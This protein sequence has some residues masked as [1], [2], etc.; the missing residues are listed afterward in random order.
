MKAFIGS[1][2]IGLSRAKKLKEKL[3]EESNGRIECILWTEN[4]AFKLS[5]TTIESL[6]NIGKDLR[7]TQGKAILI[8]TPDDRITIDYNRKNAKTYITARDNVIYELGLFGGMLGQENVFCVM[9]GNIEDFR[10]L[11]DYSGVNVALYNY[12]SR[13]N[14]YGF[15]EV[16]QKN[17]LCM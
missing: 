17:Y 2:K 6:F 11:T 3:E 4:E 16:A 8:L 12:K 5:R 9:P 1:S 13:K 7:K 10:M 14:S 15:N